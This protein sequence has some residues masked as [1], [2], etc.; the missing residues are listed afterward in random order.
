[1]TFTLGFNSIARLRTCDP[2]LQ[3][4]VE[5]ALSHSD[6]DFS[7]VE[8]LR[9][10]ENQQKNID[11]G[12]SWTMDSKHIADET[13][14]SRAVDIYPWVDGATSHDREHYKRIAKAMFRACQELNVELEWGGFWRNPREDSPHFELV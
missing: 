4:V 1:M 8:G 12:V 3:R 7:V 10:R 9:S 5:L 11:N 14:Y 2:Q 13:G 6:V